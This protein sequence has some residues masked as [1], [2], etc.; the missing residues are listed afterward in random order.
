MVFLVVVIF[1]LGIQCAETDCQDSYT[2]VLMS[3]LL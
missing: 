1:L 3:Y 2:E